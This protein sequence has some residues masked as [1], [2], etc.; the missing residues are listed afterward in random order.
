MVFSTPVL[1]GGEFFTGKDE[2][3]PDTAESVLAACL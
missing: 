1:A 3:A 2:E